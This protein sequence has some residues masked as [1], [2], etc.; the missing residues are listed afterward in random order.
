M[1]R[2]N[3]AKSVRYLLAFHIQMLK[4]CIYEQLCRRAYTMVYK[5]FP[6]H[7]YQ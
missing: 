2:R 1:D 3:I 4:L 5:Y 7:H 6:I